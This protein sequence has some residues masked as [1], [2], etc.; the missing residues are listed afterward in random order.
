V[1]LYPVNNENLADTYLLQL[2]DQEATSRPIILK[3]TTQQQ[4]NETNG[5][6]KPLVL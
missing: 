4:L 1:L 2:M 6:D 3:G 5:E